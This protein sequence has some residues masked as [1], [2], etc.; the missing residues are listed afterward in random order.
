MLRVDLTGQVFNRLTVVERTIG[1]AQR[2]TW[3][4]SCICGNIVLVI[5][6]ELRN[7][8]TQSC[9]CLRRDTVRK[10]NN[11]VRAAGVVFTTREYHAWAA[12]RRRCNGTWHPSYKNYGGRGIKV[13]ERWSVFKNFLADMGPM[14]VGASID[15]IDNNRGYTPDNCRWTDRKTQARNRRGCLYLTIDGVSRHIKSWCE[16]RGVKYTSV[17][18]RRRRGV[19]LL[20]ALNGGTKLSQKDCPV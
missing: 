5:T 14:P 9:G 1:Q 15:R 20:E 16:L 4:C 7:G 13:C 6:A 10:R 8:H 19:P 3:K 2:V 17:M 18:S 11:K 12:M